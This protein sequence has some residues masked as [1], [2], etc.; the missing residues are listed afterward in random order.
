MPSASLRIDAGVRIGPYLVERRLSQS[1]TGN[2]YVARDASGALAV[3]RLLHPES[4]TRAA[5]ARLRREARALAGVDHPGVVR[6][7]GVGEQEG[8]LWIATNY[9]RGTDIG[10]QLDERGPLAIDMALR[11]AI[12]AAE[13]LVAAHDAGAIHRDL[14]PANMVL[15]LDERVVLVD[16]GIGPRADGDDLTTGVR[17]PLAGVTPYSAPEQIEH[18]LADERSDLWALG[19][20]LYE[21]IVGAPP[22]GKAGSATT[23]AIL[24]DEPAFPSIVPSVVVHTVNACLRK[25][26]FARI[27]TSRELLALLRDALEGVQSPS[28]P[29]GE[30]PSPY[31]SG[32]PHFPVSGIIPPPPRLPSVWLS[33]RPSDSGPAHPPSSRTRVA[34]VRGRIKGAAV[35]AGIAWFAET[36]GESSLARIVELASPELRAILRPKDPVF[37]LITSGWYETQRIGELIELIERVAAPADPASFGAAIGE[38]IARDNV[39]GVHRALFRTVATPSSLEANAQRVW[40]TYVDEGTFSVRMRSRSSFD[41]KARGWARHHPSV[42]RIL[43]AMLESS[44]RTVGYSSLIL[45]RRQCV[46]LGDPHCIFSGN[47]TVES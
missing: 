36:Y 41:A 35:R 4:P 46:G 45:A 24:R 22:F 32:R 6:V 16:F 3:L 2:L 5:R 19:C 28:V 9:V 21:M 27:A 1:R 17:S 43:R 33:S 18:G 7:C 23:T 8:I 29:A 12:Q 38:A 20:V 11:H 40:R 39:G 30:R 26:S 42:C 10:R 44:L 34:A 37:G 14:K 15:T 13:A 47:W 31:S 25:N